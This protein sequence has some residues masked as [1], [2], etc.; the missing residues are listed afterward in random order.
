MTDAPRKPLVDRLL[1]LAA[2]PWLMGQQALRFTFLPD[3]AAPPGPPASRPT[4]TP[5]EHAIKRRG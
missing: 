3:K 5:P 1:T 2:G 4:I